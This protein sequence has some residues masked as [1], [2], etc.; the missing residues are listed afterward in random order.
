MGVVYKARDL[1]LG[2]IVALKMIRTGAYAST[3]R[4][5]SPVAAEAKAA[6]QLDHPHIVPVFDIGTADGLPYFAM[7]YVEGGSLQ[8]RLADGPLPPRIAAR[9]VQQVAEAVQHAHDRGVVHR[10]L[11]PANILLQRDGGTSETNLAAA[12]TRPGTSLGAGPG[13][14]A[15]PASGM[16]V[17][18][19][20]DFGL[21]HL[22]GQ[23]G[24]TATG[25]V[26]GTPSYMPPE[27]AAGRV[28]EVG[29]RSDVYS[30]GAVLYCL[31]TGRPPFQAATPAETQRLVLDQ[32]PVPPRRL[33][34]SVPADLQTIC[35]KCLQKAP[36]RSLPP[37][38]AALAEDLDSFLEA[39]P[40]RARPVGVLARGWLWCRRNP[41]V[42][43]LAAVA[44][45]LLVFAAVSAND[46]CP[47]CS[48]PRLLPKPRHV[49]RWKSS[50]TTTSSPSP[51]ASWP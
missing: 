32:E 12:S 34:A 41:V 25:D 16:P 19:V 26:L 38:L 48:T 2:R 10:D 27:Q 49:S 36:Q 15:A 6:A 29:P 24:L 9:V 1:K 51:S 17:P 30:L 3:S 40:I 7:A 4:S 11:K 35:L 45:T 33:N 44:T 39:R 37:A 21:A 28:H 50:S 14:S 31:L 8:E 47:S 23:D 20:S 13:S 46:S 42:A 5:R 22:A 43:S 18:K